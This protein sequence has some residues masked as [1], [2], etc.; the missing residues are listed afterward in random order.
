M[1]SDGSGTYS[2]TAVADFAT[3]AQGTKADS[4]VQPA[5]ISA[6]VE[7]TDSIDVLSDVDTS[8]AAPTSGQVLSMESVPNGLQVLLRRAGLDF[9]S[10][11][12]LV[13]SMLLLIQVTL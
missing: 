6:M 12:K 1:T 8:T 4:A 2:I 9:D 10:Q 11:L 3:A 7:T 13:H 5:A